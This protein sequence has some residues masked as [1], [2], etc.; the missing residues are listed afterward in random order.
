MPDFIRWFESITLQDLPLVGGKNASLGE[1]YGT[2]ASLGVKIPN[3]FAITAYAYWHTLDSAGVRGELQSLL[4]GLNKQDV[5]ELARRGA[6]AR[7]LIRR[8]G[9][10][11]D[12]WS[13]I[14]TAYEG[15][16]T[17][18]GAHTDMAV[19]SSATAEDL[20]GASFAGQQESYLN[21]RGYA[22]LRDAC[23]KC[24]ASLFTDRAISYRMDQGFDHFQ[25]ALSIG[26]QKMVR[27]DLASAG[28]VFF[29]DTE[30]RFFH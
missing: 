16:C 30:T 2:L 6:L 28:G 4:A 9:I 12:L 21:I 22:A 24:F 29:I 13:E 11:D 10:P 3:G 14:R 5:A 7:D 15:L 19:R 1:M 17:Q 20:P 27:S 8:A 26:V 18:Y 25:V 23:S